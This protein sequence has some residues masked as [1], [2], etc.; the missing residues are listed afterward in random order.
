MTGLAGPGLGAEPQAASNAL[1]EA[2]KA[3]R[4]PRRICWNIVMCFRLARP[5]TLR[6]Q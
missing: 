6:V 1:A 3:S 5:Q 2:S 4:T